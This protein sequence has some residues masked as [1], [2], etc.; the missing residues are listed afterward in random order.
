MP[1]GEHV[2]GVVCGRAMMQQCVV[3][4]LWIADVVHP[5]LACH[6]WMSHVTVSRLG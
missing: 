1:T 4:P 6:L 5:T 3:V 2:P